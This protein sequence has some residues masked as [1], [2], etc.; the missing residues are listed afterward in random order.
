MKTDMIFFHFACELMSLCKCITIKQIVRIAY[1]VYLILIG[2]SHKLSKLEK[3]AFETWSSKDILKLIPPCFKIITQTG[4]KLV[5][6]STIF[7]LIQQTCKR[8]WQ[9]MCCGNG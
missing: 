1:I 9:Y 8:V 7:H 6:L 2:Q 5:K 4:N 3:T